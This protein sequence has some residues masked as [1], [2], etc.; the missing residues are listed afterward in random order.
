M[1]KINQ[2][3]KRL[4]SNENFQKRY[5]QIRNE[6]LQHPDVKAFL[7][8]NQNQVNKEMIEKSMTKLF[9]YIN[10]SEDCNECP[11]LEA[12]E[13]IMKGYHPKLVLTRNIH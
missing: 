11:N 8:E 7:A 1:E 4:A 9:E 3:L 2:T 12:C 10:Q 5:E 13:N 6:V